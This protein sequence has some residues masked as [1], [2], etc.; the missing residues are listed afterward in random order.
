MCK[1]EST[2]KYF[3]FWLE[4]EIKSENWDHCTME[5]AKKNVKDFRILIMD[6]DS[7]LSPR[8]SR[9]C[10]YIITERKQEL[11]ANL[12]YFLSGD[13]GWEIKNILN[14]KKRRVV[15][16]VI[17]EDL[18]CEGFVKKNL[19][20]SAGIRLEIA[21]SEKIYLY[22]HTFLRFPDSCQQRE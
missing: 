18:V 20:A 8:H 4:G 15:C 2:H 10:D 11:K 21:N 7:F 1:K 17:Y 14:K 12:P 22:P 6:F 13:S 3:S 19:L 5:E 16:W 9:W